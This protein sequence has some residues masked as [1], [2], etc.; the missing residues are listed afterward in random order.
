MEYGA[1]V[2]LTQQEMRAK[3]DAGENALLTSLR[4]AL[5]PAVADRARDLAESSLKAGGVELAADKIIDYLER[6]S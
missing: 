6:I 1:G 5:E 3:W 4:A 2:L